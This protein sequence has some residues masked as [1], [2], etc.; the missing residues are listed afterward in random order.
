MLPKM[1]VKG[2]K[3]VYAYIACKKDMIELNLHRWI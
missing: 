3:V 2:E 1:I